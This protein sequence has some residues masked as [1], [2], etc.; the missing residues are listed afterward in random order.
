VEIPVSEGSPDL[1]DPILDAVRAHPKVRFAEPT[2][3]R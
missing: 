1:V 3:T 2:T